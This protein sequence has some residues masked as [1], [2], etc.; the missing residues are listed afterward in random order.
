MP[1]TFS[2]TAGRSADRADTSFIISM[3]EDITPGNEHIGPSPSALFRR[4]VVNAA[5]DLDINGKVPPRRFVTDLPYLIEHFRYEF[6]PTKP[7]ENSHD[8][9]LVNRIEIRE[10]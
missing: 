4:F 2:T 3:A 1:Q 8:E 5:V 9:H 6:L 10:E 7:G